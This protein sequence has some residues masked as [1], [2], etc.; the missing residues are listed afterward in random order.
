M[1]PSNHPQAGSARAGPAH[2]AGTAR[3]SSAYIRA[4][5]PPR[6]LCIPPE[7]SWLVAFF[8]ERSTSRLPAP[9]RPTTITM[10]SKF[11]IPGGNLIMRPHN[12]SY[13]I[14]VI[15]LEDGQ[16]PGDHIVGRVCH[17]GIET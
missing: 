15:T 14:E 2:L 11:L 1:V 5:A 17:V 13:P 4:A 7:H 3:P 8:R 12:P 6:G 9:S 16:R 10:S